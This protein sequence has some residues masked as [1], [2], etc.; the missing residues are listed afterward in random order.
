[1][2][3]LNDVA[4]E[5]GVSPG[6]VSNALSGKRPVAATTR[7]R[8]METIERLGYQPNLLARGL[9][10]GRTNA[11]GV[12]IM[13]FEFEGPALVVA[14]IEQEASQ[15]HLSLYLSVV[16]PDDPD[17][18]D[19]FQI[20]VNRRVDGIIWA[21]PE[22]GE[23]HAW[24][25]E[26]NAVRSVPIVFT[27]IGPRPGISRVAID[28]WAGAARAA[29]H[30]VERGYQRIAHISGPLDRWEGRERL[31]GWGAVLAEN[32][33]ATHRVVEGDLLAPSGAREMGEILSRWPDTEAVFVAND[34]MAI[35]A[36]HTLE[37]EGCSVPDDVA[38]IGFDDKREASYLKPSLTT[39]RQE[40][41]LEGQLAVQ[42]LIEQINNS[43]I[44]PADHI[45]EPELII[46]ESCP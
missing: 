10:M 3:N 28:N 16:K 15:H 39:I 26:I 33:L 43:D 4:R 24:L 42:A 21:M 9:A 29:R 46:R 14:G 37:R 41:R 38:V 31:Q 6:T 2:F 1:M 40:F 32:G 17:P 11:L 7:Q 30:L 34:L 44:E 36:L 12:V 13:G 27:T 25:S 22:I 5:A 20:L 8:I 18:L 35:G 19:Q 45:I 23:S